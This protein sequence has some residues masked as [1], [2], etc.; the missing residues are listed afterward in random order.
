MFHNFPNVTRLNAR[1]FNNH[2]SSVHWWSWNS[3]ESPLKKKFETVLPLDPRSSTLLSSFPRKSPT[4]LP[5]T[6]ANFP[7]PLSTPAKYSR[8]FHA[9]KYPFKKTSWTRAR[10]DARD[11]KDTKWRP[12]SFDLRFPIKGEGLA[13]RGC[14]SCQWT[15]AIR[16]RKR[17]ADSV[18][19]KNQ[20]ASARGRDWLNRGPA[21]LCYVTRPDRAKLPEV[22]VTR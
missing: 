16:E 4:P 17:F 10:V 5:N 13:P 15:R 22:C 7:F 21:E 19:P 11:S 2:F 20:V 18:Q 6:P 14:D 9:E 12:G 3:C 1:T 8:K